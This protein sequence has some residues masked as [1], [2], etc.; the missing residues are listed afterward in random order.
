MSYSSGCRGQ[1]QGFHMFL[2][3]PDCPWEGCVTRRAGAGVLAGG[4]EREAGWDSR[5]D[6]AGGVRPREGE[7]AGS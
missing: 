3:R 7:A 1:D 4:E 2:K 5:E 6:Q